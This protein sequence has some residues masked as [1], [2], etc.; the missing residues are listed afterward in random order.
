M[1]EHSGLDTPFSCRSSNR[2]F[3]MWLIE[4]IS[5]PQ[6][7]GERLHMGAEPSTT[8]M[9]L[10]RLSFILNRICEERP[11]ELHEIGQ[12]LRARAKQIEQPV[13]P[14]VGYAHLETR[15][16]KERSDSSR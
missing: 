16:L 11:R 9:L 14:G 10:D 6:C 13:E 3:H 8:Q 7:G 5:R 4:G 2:S 15:L 12:F 1:D